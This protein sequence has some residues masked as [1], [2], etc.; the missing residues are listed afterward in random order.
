VATATRLTLGGQTVQPGTRQAVRLPVTV[1]LNG[2]ELAVWVHA[3]HGAESGPAIALLSGL[4]GGEWFCVEAL[5]RLVLHTDPRRLRGSLL[6][7][8]IANGPALALNTRNIP[9]ESDSPDANRIFPGPLTWT[10]DQIIATISREV[11]PHATCLMDL[12]MGPLG[13]AFQD[14]LIGSEY[15]KAGV[16]EESE[17]LALAFGSPIVRRANVMVGFPGPRSSIG[18]G[19]GVLGIPSLG[20]E[21]GGAGFGRR[22]EERW[23]RATV[24]GI[25]AVMGALGMIE[26]APDP[27]PARQLVYEKAYR[28]NPTRGGILH[29]RFGADALATSVEQ[30]ALLGEVISPYTFEVLEELRAPA[31]GLLYYV[32]RDYPVHPGDWAFGVASTGEGAARWVENE[33]MG[34]NR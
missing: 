21:V 26:D 5:R 12:H 6:V 22:V 31:D 2:A 28:V 27:R 8:P 20:V 4:H 13:S 30:G 24:D 33:K 10:S 19:G 23:H 3:V 16:A 29:S 9:D 15:P 11:L 17:R 1:G 7:V 34:A 14:I 32:A 25:H 18:Y